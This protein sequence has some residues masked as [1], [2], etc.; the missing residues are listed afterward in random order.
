MTAVMD[1]CGGIDVRVPNSICAI[2]FL[3]PTICAVSQSGA[4]GS[5]NISEIFSVADQNGDQLIDA[6]EVDN[7]KGQ[8]NGQG[9]WRTIR[10]YFSLIDADR[11][12][13]ITAQELISGFSRPDLQAYRASRKRGVQDPALMAPPAPAGINSN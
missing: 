9:V 10:K 2:A 13:G 7:L 12:G 4:A 6:S 1:C 3:I 11:S 5:I 8:G